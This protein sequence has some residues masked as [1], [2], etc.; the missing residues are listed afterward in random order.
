MIFFIAGLHNREYYVFFI[1][2]MPMGMSIIMIVMFIIII[3]TMEM[4]VIM[5]VRGFRS[6]VCSQQ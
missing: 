5:M 6:A 4:F 1:I 2:I 3:M